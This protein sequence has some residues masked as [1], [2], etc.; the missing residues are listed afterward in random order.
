MAK[1]RNMAKKPAHYIAQANRK[2]F[3]IS[4]MKEIVT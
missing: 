1:F 2:R 4:G 3:G